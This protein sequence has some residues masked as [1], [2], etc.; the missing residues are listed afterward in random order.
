MLIWYR[1]AQDFVLSV[2]T[3]VKRVEWPTRNEV[4]FN[5]IIVFILAVIFSIFFLA[6]DQIIICALRWGIGYGYE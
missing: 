3:E 2:F 1:Q 4:I 5:V 6:I